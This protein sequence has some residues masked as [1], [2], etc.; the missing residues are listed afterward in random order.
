MPNYKNPRLAAERRTKDL[1]SRM[2]LEEKAAQMTCVWQ[3]KAE[4]LVDA[5]GDFDLAK[6]RAAFKDGNGLQR[7]SRAAQ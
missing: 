7:T 3:K 4:V 2:T 5:N 6:A 1:L